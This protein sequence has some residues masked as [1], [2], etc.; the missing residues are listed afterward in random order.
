MPLETHREFQDV[1]RL[2]WPYV[3][4]WGM[5]HGLLYNSISDLYRGDDGRM[6]AL[7]K[8]IEE[9]RC[10]RRSH[11]CPNDQSA[12]THLLLSYYH[13][14]LAGMAGTSPPPAGVD[15]KIDRKERPHTQ[16]GIARISDGA[17]CAIYSLLISKLR[18]GL[19][20]L[21]Q[22]TQSTFTLQCVCA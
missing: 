17:S 8:L 14:A 3:V 10:Q 12:D 2:W 16:C 5:R 4:V 18:T 1:D 15:R 19:L 11:R 7:W 9:R 6:C 20:I 22:Q 13:V 21:D